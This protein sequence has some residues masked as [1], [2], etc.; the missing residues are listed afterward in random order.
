MDVP[1]PRRRTRLRRVII[2]AVLT[3]VGGGLTVSIS[4]LKPAAATVERATVWTDTVKRGSILRQVRGSGAL[5]PEEVRWVTAQSPG[6]VDRILL[7]PGVAVAPDTVLVELSNPELQHGV[8]E[9]ESQLRAAEAQRQRLGLQLQSERLAQESVVASLRSDLTIARI[10][11][12]GDEELRAKGH[13]PDLLAKKSRAKASELEGRVTL[14][15]KRLDTVGRSARAQ[16]VVQDAEISRLRAEL[17]LRHEQVAAL[18]VRAG[19]AGVLQRLGDEQPVRV[20]QHV[21]AGGVIAR[22]ANQAKLKAE[23]KIAETQAK[24]IQLGQVASI[25]TRN[26]MVAGHIVRIDPAVQGGTVTVDVALDAA[27]PKGA[28]P[29]LTVDG[30]VTLERLESVLYVVRPVGIEAET[31]T[32]LFKVLDLGRVA[33]RVPVRLG[34][35]S[36]DVVEV[37]EG[38]SVGDQVIVSDMSQWDAHDRL[39]L[40]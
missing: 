31:R 35:G 24:D 3:A 14:E 23:V 37:L 26:G 33:I 19:I 5:V 29:D 6:R 7:L 38:L 11:A 2:A 4:R 34:R 28:R 27:L 10:E 16:I 36:V 30:L 13:G 8:I 9:L 17:R 20:G 21:A 18:T 25:D 1:R 15:G 32:R 39:R 40:N 12:E 22:I